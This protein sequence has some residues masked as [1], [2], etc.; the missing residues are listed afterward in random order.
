MDRAGKA[1]ILGE[2]KEQFSNVI[3]VVIADWSGISVPVVTAMREDF[4]KNGCQY[5]VLKNSLVK[6]AVKGTELEPIATLMK[7]TTAVIWSSETAQAP[8]KIAL[9]WSKDQPKFQVKGGF[10]EGKLLDVKGV[11]ALSKLPTKPEIQGQLFMTFLAA[12][13]QFVRLLEARRTS[14]ETAA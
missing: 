5:R 8:A 12:P 4:R 2:V 14:L 3:S 7:G 13:S 11:D 1:E 10:Y 6:I 9:K